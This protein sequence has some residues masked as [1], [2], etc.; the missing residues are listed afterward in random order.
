MIRMKFIG[1]ILLALAV[2][3]PS[4][5][6]SEDLGLSRVTLIEGDLEIAEGEDGE[7]FPASINMPLREGDRL[8]V[9]EA[10]RAEIHLL[11][12]TY[13]RLD[14]FT[15]FELLSLSE[16]SA[17][18]Y[19]H[20]GR[21]YVN[22]LRAGRKAMVVETPLA[23]VSSLDNARYIV[24]VSDT[25]ESEVSVV[26]GYAYVEH[27]GGS[28]RI[29]A[30]ETL[31]VGPGAYAEISPL[32]EPGEWERW[33]RELD[34]MATSRVE[35]ARYLPEELHEFAYEL[36]HYGRWHYASEYGYVW[37]PTIVSTAGWSPYRHGR[38][39]RVGVEYVWISY[40]P[41]GWAPYHYGRWAHV[42]GIGWAWVPPPHHAVYW[43]PGYVDW[44]YTP[45]YVAWVPLA[46]GE[47]YYGYGY[48]GPLS[49]NIINID[50]HKRVIKRRHRN[51]HVPGSLTFLHKD[52]KGHFRPGG[53]GRSFHD[54]G[55]FYGPPRGKD[56][57]KFFN[58]MKDSPRTDLARGDRT[59]P[60]RKSPA[61]PPGPANKRVFTKGRSFDRKDTLRAAP[62]STL[63]AAPEKKVR[64]PGTRFVSE[65][66]RT[67]PARWESRPAQPA[68]DV[69]K[70]RTVQRQ[71]TVRKYD[72]KTRVITEKET[73]GSPSRNR[74]IE[75][76]PV[77]DTR[78]PRVERY[79]Q[80]A[81]KR[82]PIRTRPT[83]STLRVEKK[84]TVKT[85]RRRKAPATAPLLIKQK[86]VS[87][88]AAPKAN[89]RSSTGRPTVQ[90]KSPAQV[91]Q[92]KGVQVKNIKR[93]DDKESRQS[94]GRQGVQSR[95]PV[96]TQK[97]QRMQTRGSRWQGRMR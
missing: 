90:K 93:V 85:D 78:K 30:G 70:P 83:V 28:A 14:E 88:R 36:D 66:G 96:K 64:Q 82:Q 8:R 29:R 40:E 20:E 61:G 72:A 15:E 49:V 37:A 97:T 44:W 69:R 65:K 58:H 21:I 74:Y 11:G 38:W 87:A 17:G 5:V 67:G 59:V 19:L 52:R 84:Q 33:N 73:A 79:T 23:S 24:R 94:Y 13:L 34:G 9:S 41:W 4:S 10:S 54:D 63:R 35:S 48:Y 45:T 27:R 81:E 3:V 51:F 80:P 62:G 47:V 91:R 39:S 53:K 55:K 18:G 7:W 60:V 89:V 22:D 25:G 16:E 50:I 2:L 57:G 43:G 26:M 71:E 31:L 1:L 68:Q 86:R 12:G 46:P 32:G 95:G 6:R 42:G 56:A 77:K 75:S 76:R 92:T